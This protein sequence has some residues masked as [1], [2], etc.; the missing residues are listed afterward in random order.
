M[1]EFLLVLYGDCDRF[2]VKRNFSVKAH[3]EDDYLFLGYTS[4]LKVKTQRNSSL[5]T[6]Y[7]K[8]A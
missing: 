3:A 2:K 6:V 1:S 5:R 7:S 8:W 4:E